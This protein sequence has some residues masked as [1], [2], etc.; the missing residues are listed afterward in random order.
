MCG[1][2][3]GVRR[4]LRGHEPS[5]YARALGFHFTFHDGLE[6]DGATCAARPLA[7]ATEVRIDAARVRSLRTGTPAGDGDATLR[8]HEHPPH[9]WLLEAPGVGA[10]LV[11]DDGREV[12]CAPQPGSRDF[13]ALL[14]AQVVPLV[15]TLRGHEV[16]HASG[17]V[18]AGRAHLVCA[19]RGVGKT[20]LAAHLALGGAE[21]LADDVVAVDGA[22]VAHPGSVVLN[23]R[24]SERENIQRARG[25][26]RL[27][28]G[29]DRGGRGRL[30]L[31]R[32]AA[33][34]PLGGIHLLGRYRTGE[35]VVPIADPRPVELLGATFNLSVRTP[36]R[37][38]RQLALC[39]RLAAEVPVT[40]LCITPD[41]DAAALAA[42]LLAHLSARAGVGP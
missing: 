40:R 33:A 34:A 10:A 14:G 27:A 13:T 29:T 36:E 1:R 3:R 4:H 38:M 17:V 19:A 8:I 41:R 23:V 18:V 24:R 22:L 30:T 11:S 16:F 26:T 42:E 25:R 15:A 21:L 12:W 6:I 28:W 37:L 2:R 31:A 20:S 7:D 35:P 32:A 5:M 9:G 39:A